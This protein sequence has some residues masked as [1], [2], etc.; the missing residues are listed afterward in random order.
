MNGTGIRKVLGRGLFDE[1]CGRGSAMLEGGFWMPAEVTED[2]EV[3]DFELNCSQRG[4]LPAGSAVEVH[5]ARSGRRS[6]VVKM[7]ER[8]QLQYIRR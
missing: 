3:P 2:A 6:A 7:A 4:S 1:S 5:P 8:M